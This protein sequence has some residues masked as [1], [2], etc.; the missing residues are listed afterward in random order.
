[1][2]EEMQETQAS[3]MIRP[4]QPDD[5]N[6]LVELEELCFDTDR[7]SRRSFRHFLQPNQHC[8]LV[9]ETAE[10]RV[11]GYCLVFLHRG[12]HLARLYSIAIDP[13]SRGQG[14]ARQLLQQAEKLCADADR[15]SM[16]LE[17][18]KDNVA[19]IALYQ[20][21]GYRTFGEYHDYYAD[22]T[23]ALRLQK[24]IRHRKQ[25]LTAQASIPYYPQ[26]TDFTCGPAALMMA[27]ASLNPQQRLDSI[28]ELRIWREATTIYMM[29]GHGGCSPLGLALAAVCRGFQAEVYLSSPETPF[30]DSVRGEE[31]KSVVTLVHQDFLQQLAQNQTPLHYTA[32]TQIHLQQALEMGQIPLVLISTYRFD[33]C[34]VPHWVVVT[35]MDERFIY[36]HDPL[37]DA[38]IFR[39]ALDNQYLPIN[40][41]DFDKMAQFG[42]SRLRTAVIVGHGNS[43]ANEYT[44]TV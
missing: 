5:L 18:R 17:V 25:S 22:H 11:A 4:A 26:T 9:A 28:E 31:K 23:D 10:Q 19:A 39:F 42:Q 13:H 8:F 3:T 32:I 30:I 34:K 1:M 24:R 33:G 21:L 15:I 40:R 38:D 29:A 12:T 35:A 44:I 36:I 20:Q 16:R 2:T 6:R 43:L 37:I 41:S 27:M 14:I 7:M